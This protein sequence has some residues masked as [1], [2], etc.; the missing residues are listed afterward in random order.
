MCSSCFLKTKYTCLTCG[1]YFCMRC[2]V[3]ENEE[4]TP[5]WRKGKS[6]AC[7]ESCFHELMERRE[8]SQ[9]Q[10]DDAVGKEDITSDK[11]HSSI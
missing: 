10:D 7:S 1:N 3:F 5:G 6:V 9:S 4:D 11:P 2:S 8:S